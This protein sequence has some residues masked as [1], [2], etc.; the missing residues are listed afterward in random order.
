[1]SRN[2]SSSRS[3]ENPA[4]TLEDFRNALRAGMLDHGELAVLDKFFIMPR[5]FYPAKTI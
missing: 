5:Q 3:H 2:P 1:M 4:Q